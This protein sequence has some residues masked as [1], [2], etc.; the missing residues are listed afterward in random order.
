MDLFW[1]VIN[2]EENPPVIETQVHLLK[3]KK[4]K[5]VSA[6]SWLWNTYYLP[7]M[8][9]ELSPELGGRRC[10]FRDIHPAL[11]KPLPRWPAQSLQEGACH[12]PCLA[13]PS[14]QTA[15]TWLSTEHLSLCHSYW[16]EK[17]EIA[18]EIR[19]HLPCGVECSHTICALEV[20]CARPRFQKSFD[21]LTVNL[22]CLL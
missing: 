18:L 6:H 1:R 5:S 7:I 11:P 9:H 10:Q 15:F 17:G 3:K 4:K 12:A 8:T 13:W 14:L 2:G 21:R 22:S 19:Q 20:S 16:S